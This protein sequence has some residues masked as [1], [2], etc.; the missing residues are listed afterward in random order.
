MRSTPEMVTAEA[1]IA[2]DQPLAGLVSWAVWIPALAATMAYPI[3]VTLFVDSYHAAKVGSA[4]WS[5]SAIAA[6]AVACAVP[7]LALRGLNAIRL[8]TTYQAIAVRRLLHL[9][10]A[11]PPLYLLSGRVS[12]L[13]SPLFG[14]AASAPILWWGIWLALAVLVWIGGPGRAG[15]EPRPAQ[16]AGDGSQQRSMALSSVRVRNIHRIAVIAIVVTFLVMHLA[17]HLVALW[18]VSWQRATM[19]ALRSWYRAVW[20]E[21]VI[22]GLFV[23][24]ALSGL[25]RLARLTR[26]ASDGFRVLQTA[27]AAYLACFLVSHLWATLGARYRG[28]DSDWAFATGGKAGLLASGW[29]MAVLIYYA[30]ALLAV[31]VHVGLGLRMLLLFNHVQ[32]AAA[33]RAARLTVVASSLISILIVAALVGVRLGR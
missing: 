11:V 22:L 14:K 25:V 15:S 3:A 18:S 20:M 21:P 33:N 26:S 13:L 5:L 28:I 30:F 27:S 10:V 29:S 1:R 7:L 17:N 12:G 8:A 16:T 32:P 19:L 6:L 4:A 9:A 2:Q 24:A 23:V 31:A